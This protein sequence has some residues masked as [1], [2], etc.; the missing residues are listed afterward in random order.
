[1]LRHGDHEE[2]SIFTPEN[3][4][5][6]A[7]RQKAIVKQK[8]PPTCVLDPDGDIV[9]YLRRRRRASR[10][11]HW[12]CYHSVLYESHLSTGP[13]GIVGCAV[14]APF[15]V[16]VAE[17]MF[18]SGCTLLLSITSAGKVRSQVGAPRYLV[19]SKA[20]RDEGTSDR[21][22]P[23][24]DYA[25]I[26][27]GLLAILQVH[28]AESPVLLG[29]GTSWTTDAPFR[30]TASAINRARDRGAMCVEMEAA[31][32]YAFAQACNRDVVCVAHL[33]NTMAQ[34]KG[35]FEKGA[36]NGSV[37]SLKLIEF[38]VQTL[39]WHRKNID[40]AASAARAPVDTRVNTPR[41]RRRPRKVQGDL[42]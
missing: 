4:L 39:R 38:L 8:I 23:S 15:A 26:R 10:N 36:D 21:Y 37:D 2:A 6:E 25:K 14:G 16:L 33:T 13:V 40:V 29:T 7:R 12:A 28:L 31:A 24:G 17:E 3:L 1:V 27:D 34:S 42:P 5:R 18:A 41:L 11:P 20:L 22:L 30:E 9:K 35:D 19:L 32:L